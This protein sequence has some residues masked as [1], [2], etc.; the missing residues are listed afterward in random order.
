MNYNNETSGGS[1]GSEVPSAD[2]IDGWQIRNSDYNSI[3]TSSLSPFVQLIGLYNQEEI[4]KLIQ[5]DQEAGGRTVTYVNDDG[6]W[7]G[8]TEEN[9][10]ADQREYFTNQ[11]KDKF[12]EINIQNYNGYVDIN[13]IVLATNS[14]QVGN[15]AYET[16]D[17]GLPKDSGGIGITD[18][19]IETGTKDFMNRRYK[20]RLTVTDPFILNDQKEYLKLST[21]Q[22]QFL[23]I[24][25][26]ANPHQIDGMDQFDPPPQINNGRMSVDLTNQNT[27]GMWSAATVAI[28]MF[29]FAFNEQGQLEAN[30][31]FMPRDI[32]FAATYRIGL[33]SEN[34]KLFLGTGEQTN[35]QTEED[36]EING[37][38]NYD[39][40][41]LVAGFGSVAGEFGKNIADIIDEEQQNYFNNNPGVA[42]L[43]SNMNLNFD[44]GDALRNI[45]EEISQWSEA[46]GNVNM[47][48]LMDRQKRAEERNRFP[49]AG[50]GIRIYSEETTERFSD[51]ND[52]DSEVIQ[53][54]LRRSN[55]Q[56]YYL[57][58]LLEAVR[59]S[60]WDLNKNRVRNGQTPFD[61]K[62]K[63]YPVPEDS[64]FNLA[65]QDYLQA[66]THNAVKEIYPELVKSAKTNFLP[67][68]RRWDSV[69]QELFGKKVNSGPF[70][71]RTAKT[72]GVDLDWQL[73]NIS[74]VPVSADDI[75]NR[76]AMFFGQPSKFGVGNPKPAYIVQR[77]DNDADPIN[78]DHPLFNN[79]PNLNR[80]EKFDI[81]RIMTNSSAFEFE[82]D[83]E[84]N[85]REKVVVNSD[86]GENEP[87]ADYR[88]CLF[89]V[90]ETDPAYDPNNILVR[91]MHPDFDGQLLYNWTWKDKRLCAESNKSY[92][93]NSRSDFGSYQV[94]NSPGPAGA[95]HPTG[96]TSRDTPE[97]QAGYWIYSKL[98]NFFVGEILL[99]TVYQRNPYGE[100]EMRTLEH[101]VPDGYM[102][103]TGLGIIMPAVSAR[104][105][106][107][108]LYLDTQQSW[109]NKH[110]K[111]LKNKMES[112]IREKV[113]D[114][115]KFSL[116]AIMNEALP[117][118]LAHHPIDL[119][120]L[121]GRVYD[122]K[123]P[124]FFNDEDGNRHS[125]G[126]GGEKPNW[127]R[128][129]Y[130]RGGTFQ[131]RAQPYGLR[132]YNPSNIVYG[133]NPDGLIDILNDQIFATYER[134]VARDI[135]LRGTENTLQAS[136]EYQMGL[137]Q[138][139]S[140]IS[141]IESY[142]E[143]QIFQQYDRVASIIKNTDGQE[144]VPDFWANKL[145][146]IVVLFY[147]K[148]LIDIDSDTVVRR[149][150]S[151][152]TE[153][154]AHL[155]PD[156]ET[157]FQD[158]GWKEAL[159]KWMTT[160]PQHYRE[161]LAE[162]QERAVLGTLRSYP[163][164]FDYQV[165]TGRAPAGKL[166]VP[167]GQ[168][169]N[170]EFNRT[171]EELYNLNNLESNQN[172]RYVIGESP[173]IENFSNVKNYRFGFYRGA[174]PVSTPNY[175]ISFEEW[176]KDTS[177]FIKNQ[178]SPTYG[179]YLF[180]TYDI[181]NTN[182]IFNIQHLD[183]MGE[184]DLDSEAGLNCIFINFLSENNRNSWVSGDNLA[185]AADN[186]D[187]PAQM[188]ISYAKSNYE[189]FV[190]KYRAIA[191][192]CSTKY[193]EANNE[194]ESL[195][196]AQEFD[197]ENYDRLNVELTNNNSIIERLNNRE[198]LSPFTPPTSILDQSYSWSR[199]GGRYI[200]LDGLVAQQ[201]AARFDNR[202]KY[203]VSDITNYN[204]PVG[205]LSLPNTNSSN[206]GWGGATEPDNVAVY[207][208]N[209]VRENAAQI[210][211]SFIVPAQFDESGRPRSILDIEK[212]SDP[213][214]TY[215]Y[216]GQTYNIRGKGK[217]YSNED[218]QP[219]AIISDFGD[220]NNKNILFYARD[221]NNPSD[222]ITGRFQAGIESAPFPIK[223][224]VRAGVVNIDLI[225]DILSKNYLYRDK[226]F[227]LEGENSD[228][229]YTISGGWPLLN[230][231]WLPHNT[232]QA[233]VDS[234]G[235]K[236]YGDFSHASYIGPAHLVDTDLDFVI[237]VVDVFP[238]PVNYQT[239]STINLGPSPI[240]S[241]V[242]GD[243]VVTYKYD[244]NGTLFLWQETWSAGENEDGGQTWEQGHDW[245]SVN[246][247]FDDYI[248]LN[249]KLVKYF[250]SMGGTARRGFFFQ[251]HG[252]FSSTESL[253][254]YPNQ[255][256]ITTEA[257]GQRTNI[258]T[259]G[260]HVPSLPVTLAE[261]MVMINTNLSDIGSYGTFNSS[262][263]PVT[264]VKNPYGI[265][266]QDGRNGR[267]NTDGSGTTNP[268]RIE[269]I[270]DDKVIMNGRFPI[271]YSTGRDWPGPL[272]KSGVCVHDILSTLPNDFQKGFFS[273]NSFADV[274]FGGGTPLDRGLV[275]YLTEDF[276]HLFTNGRR[277]AKR[278]SDSLKGGSLSKTS[279]FRNIMRDDVTFKDLLESA[280]LEGSGLTRADFSNQI[281]A[282][283]AEIPIKREVVD[284][285]LS[286]RNPNMSIL[287]FLQQI[288]TPNAI[289]LAGNVQLGVRNYNGVIDIVPASISYKQQATDFF[290][291]QLDNQVEKERGEGNGSTM[292]HLL[293]E[294]KKR[295]SLIENIDM[296][297]K[298]DPA[299]FLTYQNSSDLLLGRDYNVLKLLSYEGVAEDFKE[300]LD[301]TQR[302]DN[303]G[304]TYSGIIT[305]GSDN[306]VTVD[307]T[308][309]KELPSSI[310]DSMIAQNP[311][312][313]AKITAMMQGNN[314]FT[315][316]LLAFYMRGVTLTIHGTT[317]LQPF[318]LI[319]VSGVMPDLE[320]IY[321]ITNL[322]EK[323]TPTTFQT[324]IEGKL[325]KRKRQS[326]GA[327]I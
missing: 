163:D 54:T 233:S 264:T 17:N 127:K 240:D 272:A 179:R 285:L 29:D 204:P 214:A 3:D 65:F 96:S 302:V 258:L 294:Y 63:Y 241:S 230:N 94:L 173:A 254:V 325:L 125:A 78:T 79:W 261:K 239:N 99:Y 170:E 190:L 278:S 195:K 161:E 26:W 281:I 145:R 143:E 305:V 155:F 323:V 219:D 225:K 274:N 308:R 5:K 210:L 292:R 44:A 126:Q 296:S 159:N 122:H 218:Q 52:T 257:N 66:G 293:F 188:M 89:E 207:D 104:Y 221:Q 183:K 290:K 48:V 69:A 71:G 22:S 318:N 60:M 191:K 45:S 231:Y 130:N 220:N 90:G 112:L 256:I 311:E 250:R 64:Q 120:Y 174:T 324:I 205:G 16:Y 137:S 42:G 30:F 176:K 197:Q 165:D 169:Q 295:N 217:Y 265:K 134:M 146:D 108:G 135:S 234:L 84:E 238:Y 319:N 15:D 141:N 317:N 182:D 136:G 19:Q 209:G 131:S 160:N 279:G 270:G 33:L 129:I 147:N 13:G 266:S 175:D 27:G 7:D 186:G 119:E 87:V 128:T 24:H 102:K 277:M 199:G 50:P 97:S 224:L 138:L 316:E 263:R 100:Y 81:L 31:T 211:K 202:T 9:I 229:A 208:D 82:F 98:N 192:Y 286:R 49:Y 117:N 88:K 247:K 193:K 327:Y 114:S 251:G 110:I 252:S 262:G 2:V 223:Y 245:V 70:T 269:L 198:A 12:V 298:M 196:L 103:N 56:Y 248:K 92:L 40:L 10:I 142:S 106:T 216:D 93:E 237:S 187:R 158:L 107:P 273:S 35:A 201:W 72:D 299:A 284:N 8:E 51:P 133:A 255:K 36:I 61:L 306:R 226:D 215:R 200:N 32:S 246:L 260:D 267:I 111:F 153:G 166:V 249:S 67:K 181:G 85:V 58:W 326:D 212:L 23:L 314:N 172:P 41:G 235:V 105:Y 232:R 271:R 227:K 38:Q 280:E 53:T 283:V 303:S 287:Q 300:F 34:I 259:D 59:F 301:G 276:I 149:P 253:D 177:N 236:Q 20:L 304:Q 162:Y 289:G 116:G 154:G 14:S 77:S 194:L 118:G 113:F 74:C 43:F 310:V 139:E 6:E 55:I 18:L 228:A 242:G 164:Q 91:I 148:D 123:L 178:V 1:I 268:V 151:L 189:N 132:D 62:F 222:N 156:G 75:K 203:G 28:T 184:L 167:Q 307:K 39:F 244:Q 95:G 157:A 315:T 243:G 83:D 282:N 313:F 124:Y 115:G 68:E 101:S 46:T 322:T 109:Y 73:Q 171:V 288:L 57:G 11:I 213:N 4:D 275:K 206:W 309:F 291:E 25:G 180:P 168:N 312:R 152:Y 185:K 297:S 37:E 320:G 140:A 121:T 321:I 76:F 150:N 86:T 80:Q 21:L 47:G 144:S